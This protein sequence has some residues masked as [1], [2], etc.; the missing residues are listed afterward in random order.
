MKKLIAAATA[1]LTLTVGVVIVAPNVVMASSALDD[2]IVASAV[3]EAGGEILLTRDPVDCPG[4]S[5]AAMSTDASGRVIHTGCWRLVGKRVAILWEP[6]GTAI[7]AEA[8][9]FTLEGRP[10][11][12][13]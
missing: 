6:S 7:I 3:N 10:W 9:R 11:P 4:K 13:R 5:H 2:L 8:E 12:R 1:A